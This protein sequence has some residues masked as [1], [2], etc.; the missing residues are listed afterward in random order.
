MLIINT[1]NGNLDGESYNFKLIVTDEAGN[2]LVS[3]FDVSLS[4]KCEVATLQGADFFQSFV[5]QPLFSEQSY[6][7]TKATLSQN[8]G[9]FTYTLLNFDTGLPLNPP[10]FT[11][12]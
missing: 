2:E 5:S 8:C 9:E 6:F 7:F 4:D 11:V 12:D 1:A 10:I 3:L